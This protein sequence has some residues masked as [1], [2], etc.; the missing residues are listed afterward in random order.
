[1]V[2]LEQTF[3]FYQIVCGTVNSKTKNIIEY[4][5][6]KISHIVIVSTVFT[7]GSLLTLVRWRPS[8]QP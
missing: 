6:Y 3:F 5:T 4:S 1:M 7:L 8:P 2:I